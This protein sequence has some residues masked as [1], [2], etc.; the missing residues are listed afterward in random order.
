MLC[1]PAAALA[2][3]EHVTFDVV[4]NINTLIAVTGVILF[5]RGVWC[6]RREGGKQPCGAARG[7]G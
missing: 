1:P 6:V 7:L 3:A 2:A 5:W 4:G